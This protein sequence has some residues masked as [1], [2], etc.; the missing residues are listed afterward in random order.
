MSKKD[1]YLALI[2]GFVFGWLALLPAK[3]LGFGITPNFV[4]VSVLVFSVFSPLALLATYLL[5]R[6]MPG[7]FQFGKFA[8]VGALNTLIDLGLL[9][10]LIILTDITAGFYFSVFKAASF[11]ASLTNSYYWNKLWTFS[12]RRPVTIQEYLRFAFFTLIGLLINVSVASFVVSVLGPLFGVAPKIWANV[13]A[14]LATVVSLIWNFFAY[15][16]IVFKNA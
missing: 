10:F 5:N 12:S 1:F 7:F 3:N 8:A 15:K 2:I 6:V 9:N 11:L 16:H 14:L 4:L 13:G